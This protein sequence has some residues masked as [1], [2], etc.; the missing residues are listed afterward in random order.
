LATQLYPLVATA[1]EALN[2]NVLTRSNE[3]EFVGLDNFF[4]LFTQDP[5]FWRIV[6]NSL[7]WVL[8]ATALQLIAGTV[9]ALI[10]NQAIVARGFWR[11]LLMTPWVT[12]VVVAAIAWRW[13]FDGEYGLLNKSLELF[14]LPSVAWLGNEATVWPALLL[15]ATWKGMPYVAILVLAG[16]QGIPRDILEAAAVDGASGW[17]R[18]FYVTLPMLR[19]VLYI[20]GLIAI[21]SSWFKFEMIWALTRGGPGYATSIL[22]TYVYALSFERFDFGMGATVAV[23]AMLLVVI[24]IAVYARIFGAKDGKSR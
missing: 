2:E 10:L 20:T 8:G 22:P 1:R 9:A 23:T 6:G 21:L 18:F 16:L 17:R 5:Y 13:I 15:A 12:P 11:G 3:A 14:G 19:P 24:V 7:L 4:Q